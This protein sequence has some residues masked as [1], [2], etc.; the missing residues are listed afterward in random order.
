VDEEKVGFSFPF[1]L[2][3][4]ADVMA[5]VVAMNE[6]ALEVGQVWTSARANVDEVL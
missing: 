1:S 5:F 6:V 4:V 3:V 2:Q